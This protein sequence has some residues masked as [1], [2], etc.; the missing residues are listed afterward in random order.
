MA[1]DI[2]DPAFARAMAERL[3][4]LYKAW[5]AAPAARAGGLA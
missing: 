1:T 5:A 3:D 2:N 4:A